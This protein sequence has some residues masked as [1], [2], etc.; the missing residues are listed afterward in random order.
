MLVLG[1]NGGF[2]GGYQDVA[3]VLLEDGQII[4]AVEE[5]RLNRVKHSKGQI[6]Y[7]SII[8]ALDLAKKNINE[9]DV[10]AFHG[11]TWGKQIKVDLENYFLSH[12]NVRPKI[13]LHHHHKCHAAS[14][15]YP[16]NFDDSLVITADNSGDGD[17]M[18]IYKASKRNGLE[19]LKSYKR[20]QSLG[21]FYSL[22][23]QYC[24][25]QKDKDE[26]KLMAL[27]AKGEAK[28]DLS[29]L[30]E[31][32]NGEL[33]LNEIFLIEIPNKTPS[34][35]EQK[36]LFNNLL[37]KTLGFEKAYLGKPTQN[38][39][40]LASSAQAHLENITTKIVAFWIEKTK[41]DKVCFAGGVALN[42]RVNGVLANLNSVSS[43]Y[44]NWCSNDSGIALGAAILSS[45]LLENTKVNNHNFSGRAY[46]NIYIEKELLKLGLS[47]TAIKN[48]HNELHKQINNNKIVGFFY[49]SSE[50]GPRA[51][52][53]RSIFANP[54]QKNIQAILNQKIKTRESFR[55]FGIILR[56]KDLP[57]YFE[58][59]IKSSPYMNIVFK[60]KNDYKSLFSEVLHKDDT[61]RIQTVSNNS[62]LLSDEM[63]FL[64]NTSF[65]HNKEPIVY[66]PVDAIRTFFGSG[67]DVLII[68]NF[69][70][71][72]LR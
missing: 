14:V 70:I 42:G 3:S 71:T 56:E 6:P 19:L 58:T 24:G 8:E 10:V 2:G 62:N 47:F 57:I 72:K 38:H 28:I 52:G 40:D 39:Y 15:F 23:T 12:F 63:S 37:I 64:I 43:F 29:F 7:Y 48:P 5:E 9:I 16:S 35:T 27:A 33:K 69:M 53:N 20:P 41:V 51:L 54:S 17:S 34:P 32:E 66:S 31:F 25:F 55:P 50:F 1:I 68:E 4:A 18:H 60:V 21:V 30:I 36:M 45:K 67:L 22:I 59:E 46:S 61:C 49:G 65:N 13:E 44:T 11:K 26:F